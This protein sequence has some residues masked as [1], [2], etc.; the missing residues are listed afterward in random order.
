MRGTGMTA[1]FRTILIAAV[2]LAVAAALGY[3]AY[4]AKKKSDVGRTAMALAQ[5][6]A[7]H[8]QDA[9]VA[10]PVRPSSETAQAVGEYAAAA[11]RNLET[12]KRL[13]AAGSQPLVDALDDFLL[14]S[15]EILARQ[16][17]GLRFRRQLLGSSQA[18]REH[19]RADN[20]TGAWV[21]EAVQHKDRVEK[22][23]RDYASA[24]EALDKLLESFP[25]SVARLA[26]RSKAAPLV[27]EKLIA[28]ARK[29]SS[30]ALKQATEEVEKIRQFAVP[31]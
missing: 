5:E 4:G 14:T 16:A 15:R 1:G 22:D 12:L 21:R 7:R 10:D 27:D 24:A 19:M 29:R 26:S 3:W 9:L 25:A 17:A 18:L 28:E 20:R 6:T 11:S 30:V 23:Y 2:A 13:D 31:R 8:L